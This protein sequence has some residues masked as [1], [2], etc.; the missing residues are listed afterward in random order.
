[1]ACSGQLQ[2]QI[3]FAVRRDI[4][5]CRGVRP[6]FRDARAVAGDLPHK[7]AVVPEICEIQIVVD[8]QGMGLCVEGNDSRGAVD[9]LE[10]HQA[11]VRSAVGIDQAVHA[12][13]AEVRIFP[14]VAAV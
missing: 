10:L 13:V 6:S 5:Q 4:Q 14:V 12:E 1:M 8:A 2:R 11:G 3:L 9:I 7:Q